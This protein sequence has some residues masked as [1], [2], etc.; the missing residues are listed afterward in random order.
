MK[1]LA[2]SAL[3]LSLC[4]LSGCVTGTTLYDGKNRVLTT[5]ADSDSF[6]YRDKS[7]SLHI[8]NHRPSVSTLA[9][10]TA[11]SHVIQSTGAAVATGA[12]AVITHGV[13]K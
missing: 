8:V 2:I 3:S 9:H 13:V 6:D 7:R 5:T 10:G 1:H 12:A 11:V 4:L